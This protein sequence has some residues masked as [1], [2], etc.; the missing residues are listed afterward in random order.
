[1]KWLGRISTIIMAL[2]M[3]GCVQTTL[4]STAA[5]FQEY[6]QRIDKVTASAGN[7]NEVNSRI[8]EIDPWPHYVDNRNIPAS[9]Q[10]MAGAVERYRDVSLQNKTPNPLPIQSTQ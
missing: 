8:Q 9:G 7:A 5:S 4:D 6:T 10:R 2:F 1:M 3:G